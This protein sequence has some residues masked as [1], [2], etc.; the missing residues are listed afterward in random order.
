MAFELPRDLSV[1]N[2]YV[3]E[4][5]R[6]ELFHADARVNCK[7]H[8]EPFKLLAVHTFKEGA[9]IVHVP[10][11]NIFDLAQ[12]EGDEAQ[13]VPHPGRS[14]ETRMIEMIFLST[15]RVGK[16]PDGRRLHGMRLFC[17]Q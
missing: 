10:A 17:I 16:V 15:R 1:C 5:A 4:R 13:E 6:P 14:R 7:L 2:V 12:P 9:S 11:K 3:H 8:H